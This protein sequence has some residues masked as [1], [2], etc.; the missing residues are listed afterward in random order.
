MS[1][2]TAKRIAAIRRNIDEF[3]EGYGYALHGSQEFYALLDL[4]DRGLA[5]STLLAKAREALEA[6]QNSHVKGEM[7][8]VG[9]KFFQCGLCR[10]Q[11]EGVSDAPEMH[12]AD[13][14]M[15]KVS[16]ARR[17]LEEA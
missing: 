17:A 2:I 6:V 13:C 5:V 8:T 14:P 1:E 10:N 7:W 11:W 16:V 15:R 12:T 4:A 9:G 3:G